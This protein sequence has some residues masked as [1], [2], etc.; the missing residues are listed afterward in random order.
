MRNRGTPGVNGKA[1]N[2]ERTWGPPPGSPHPAEPP[3]SAAPWACTSGLRLE[4]HPRPH[5]SQPVASACTPARPSTPKR[6]SLGS[7]GESPSVSQPSRRAR[8]ARAGRDLG[9]QAHPVT[10]SGSAVSPRSLG[11]RRGKHTPLSLPRFSGKSSPE[12][13]AGL[14]LS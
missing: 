7:A 13:Q 5:S 12:K 10:S 14:C 6:S 3:P 4:G 11:Q 8:A 1:A 2:P 9:R